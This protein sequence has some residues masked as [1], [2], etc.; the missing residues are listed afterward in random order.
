MEKNLDPGVFRHFEGLEDPRTGNAQLHPL[1][2]IVTIALCAVI[3]G[4]DGWVDV[5]NFGRA[6]KA[7]LRQFLSL[8]YGIPSHDT[9]GRLFAA[10]DPD[11]F[12]QCFRAWVNAVAKVFRAEVIA[13]DGKTARRSHDRC[14]GQRAIHMVSAWATDNRIVLGQVKTADHSNEIVA[15]PMLLKTLDI[16]DC[17]VTI[18]A[19]GCQKKVARQIIAQGGDYIL[20]LKEN[21]AQLCERVSKL[22]APVHQTGDLKYIS[23]DKTETKGKDHGRLERRTCWVIPASEWRFYLDMKDKWAGLQSVIMVTAERTVD[24]KTS[25]ESRYYI[26]SLPP[27]AESMLS[28]VRSHWGVENSLH[29]VL[30][31]AFREDESRV[32][33]G[34][35]Q[36][37]LTILRRLTLNLLRNADT[38]NGGIAARR[39]RAGWDND[40]LLQV[41]SS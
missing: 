12:E 2:S 36:Q 22:F 32:R 1:L 39:K 41:L 6:K 33:K 38:I 24:G 34:N 37:N 7:W 40:Y 28:S 4:A 30:D 21:Q 11:Q 9:F 31:M 10:L 3:C 13:I 5:E 25:T 23:H 17:V 29:W 35:G 26:S 8:P 19:M 18:D 27:D 16:K 14:L 15:I 20:A